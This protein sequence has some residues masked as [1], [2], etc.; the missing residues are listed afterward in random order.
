MSGRMD[1][2]NERGAILLTTILVMSLMATLAV[3]MF[4]DVRLAVKR[5]SHI[6]DYA[7]ADWYAKGAQDFATRYLT[8]QFGV[9]QTL[10]FNAALMQA[11]PIIFPIED[12]FISLS[13][14]DGSQCI[15][16]NRLADG[17][18]ARSFRKLL[19]N[20]GWDPLGAARLT[21]IATDWTDS[22]DQI[23]PNGA[24]DFS[25]LALNPPYR[26][27]NTDMHSPAE[28]RALLDVD[29]KQ[30]AA[31]RPFI[32][33]RPSTNEQGVAVNINT[34]TLDQAV[35]LAALLPEQGG[36]ELA[37]SLI[38][39]RP[40]GGYESIEQIMSTPAMDGIETANIDFDSLVTTPRYIWVEAEI[41]YKG[42]RRIMSLEYDISAE[43]PVLI[44][45][46]SGVDSLRLNLAGSE[47]AREEQP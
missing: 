5:T 10:E 8:D 14:R 16:V 12:G 2:D 15:D 46:Y 21:A 35:V 27:A 11:E 3:A 26:A 47:R 23:L 6:Q 4:D 19:I 31:L 29:F 22:D 32:C 13:V 9:L 43:R 38:V 33:T 28:L 17:S 34:L 18:G 42:A 44:S 7:Q 40:A 25:Y 45:R 20:L 1:K 41:V 30:Y 36:Y 24:E 37:Q 39:A